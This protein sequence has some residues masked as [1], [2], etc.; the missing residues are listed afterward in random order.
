MLLLTPLQ[1]R[2][3]TRHRCLLLKSQPLLTLETT[4]NI[5]HQFPLSLCTQAQCGVLEHPHLHAGSSCLNRPQRQNKERRQLSKTCFGPSRCRA[6]AKGRNRH[7]TCL[8]SVNNREAWLLKQNVTLELLLSFLWCGPVV[9]LAS[10]YLT[11]FFLLLLCS[12]LV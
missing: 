9:D 10:V 2:I 1:S 12:F 8:N 5:P 7:K 4:S 11:G 3:P 6:W